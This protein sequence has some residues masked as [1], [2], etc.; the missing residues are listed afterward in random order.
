M[1]LIAVSPKWLYM[2]TQCSDEQTGIWKDCFLLFWEGIIIQTHTRISIACRIWPSQ[3]FPIFHH[4]LNEEH[5][6]IKANKHWPSYTPLQSTER[7][8][9]CHK[10]TYF[11]S[12]RHQE[13]PSKW[14][15]L[16]SHW[17]P[18]IIS[19]GQPFELFDP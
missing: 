6:P 4:F 1:G 2:P 3:L 15:L 12:I 13:L 9:G 7:D 16:K 14:I 11:H 17:G 18:L 8:L 5:Y 10:R 19:L